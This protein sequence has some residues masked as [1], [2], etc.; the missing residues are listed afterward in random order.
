MITH[1]RRENSANPFADP[2]TKK[3][4]YL[5]IKRLLRY[6]QPEIDVHGPHHE[7]VS[8]TPPIVADED[9]H[10]HPK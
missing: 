6:N 7:Y 1:Y 10:L 9:G 8:R 3:Q 2:I 5:P 4:N